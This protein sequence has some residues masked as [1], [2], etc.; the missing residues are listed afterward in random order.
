[1]PCF[2][3]YYQRPVYSVVHQQVSQPS[4][5]VTQQLMIWVTILTH[6]SSS[7]HLLNILMLV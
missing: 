5:L 3:T 6:L 1:M 4:M 2:Q 7:Q